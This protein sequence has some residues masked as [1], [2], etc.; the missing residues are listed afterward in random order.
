MQILK[1]SRQRSVVQ[2]A[3][4][5]HFLQLLQTYLELL[6]NIS[7]IIAI[8]VYLCATFELIKSDKYNIIYISV[9]KMSSTFAL[10]K[11][12]YIA[13]NTNILLCEINKIT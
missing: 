3:E 6:D 1:F 5:A 12:H 8:N 7:R 13:V 11:V 10:E 2:T 4:I 9:N